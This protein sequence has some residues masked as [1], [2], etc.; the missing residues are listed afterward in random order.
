MLN[1]WSTT[2]IP[3]TLEKH[4]KHPTSGGENQASPSNMAQSQKRASNEFRRTRR[5]H[6]TETAEDYVEAVAQIEA[7]SGE[8]RGADLARLFAVSHVTVTKTI[9]RLKEEGLVDTRPYGPITLTARGRRL[10]RDSQRRHDLVYEFLVAI[11]V[12]DETAR[13]DAEGIEHHVSKETLKCFK[14]IVDGGK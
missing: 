8:C 14:K 4:R 12:S 10:A 6:A 3:D 1:C 7:D 2:L 13:I 11:G 9:A 5:D